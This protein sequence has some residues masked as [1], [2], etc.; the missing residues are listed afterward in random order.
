MDANP[1][2][3]IITPAFNCGKYLDETIRSVI[4][5]SYKNIEYIVID[6][7]S[8]DITDLVVRRY[9]NDVLYLK[10]ESNIG[11]QA[12][13]NKGLKLITGKYFMIVNSDDPLLPNCIS[14]LVEVMEANP[15]VLCVYPDWLSINEDGSVRLEVKVRDYSFKYMVE[16][17]TCL[18]SVGSM[19]R[20][21][22]IQTI[23]L[24]DE[25]YRWLGDFDYW[26]RIGR[27]GAMMRCPKT[28]AC[29]R[30]RTG[31]ASKDKSDT[32][33]KEH[34]RLATEFTDNHKAQSWAYLVAASVTDSKL[35]MIDY[36]DAAIYYYPR[37]LFDFEF[38]HALLQRTKYILRR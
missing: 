20:S 2:V 13:V 25:S 34:I 6:D 32:R 3:S 31:Q 12:T 10:N 36:L 26:L 1:K 17:H 19:F 18:P 5:Q 8:K 29:W 22:L 30:N 15:K 14:N 37:L 21:S 9:Q 23:G 24:R 35:N 28:L 16:H 4:M 11:E 27:V 33:A 7:C 38:Y